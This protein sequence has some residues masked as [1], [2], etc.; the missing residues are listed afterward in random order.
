MKD[1]TAEEADEELRAAI[2][3][4]ESDGGL[5]RFVEG[6]GL[7][8]RYFA[9]TWDSARLAIDFRLPYARV[10]FDEETQADDAAEVGG[11]LRLAILL[12]SDD[13]EGRLLA[14]G[15]AAISVSADEFGRRYAITGADGET[16]DSGDDWDSILARLGSIFTDEAEG[17]QIICP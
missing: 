16:L 1:E 9:F 2:A 3:E 6:H 14:D 11:A 5:E 8:S 12:I 17:L 4:L 13:D 7:Q 15:E 10:L